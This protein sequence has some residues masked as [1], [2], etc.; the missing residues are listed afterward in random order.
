[1]SSRREKCQLSQHRL[2]N[3][4]TVC[5]DVGDVNRSNVFA[6]FGGLDRANY[7]QALAE[8]R[9]AHAS[10]SIDYTLSD[11][12][13]VVRGAAAIDLNRRFLGDRIRVEG[14]TSSTL[15]GIKEGEVDSQ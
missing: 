11:D 3:A 5:L 12:S 4:A 1:V 6:R 13:H 10:R 2:A 8:K 9:L 14:G 7:Y 15:F